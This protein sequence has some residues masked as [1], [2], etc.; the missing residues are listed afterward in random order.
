[1]NSTSLTE[2]RS[3]QSPSLQ[4]MKR[5]GREQAMPE[6]L[7]SEENRLAEPRLPEEKFECW[8]AGVEVFWPEAKEGQRRAFLRLR[9]EKTAPVPFQEAFGYEGVKARLE[10]LGCLLGWKFRI[11]KSG[12]FFQVTKEKE[13]P[14]EEQVGEKLSAA[15]AELPATLFTGADKEE[16]KGFCQQ[17]KTLSLHWLNEEEKNWAVAKLARL[18]GQLGLAVRIEIG[19]AGKISLVRDD[20]RK[21]EEALA[22]VRLLAPLPAKSLPELE[23]ACRQYLEAHAGLPFFEVVEG[24]S[25]GEKG[26]SFFENFRRAFLYPLLKERRGELEKTQRIAIFTLARILGGVEK[27]NLRALGDW[28]Q[29]RAAKETDLNGIF[30]AILHEYELRSEGQVR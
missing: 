1:M 19:D 25:Q 12:E 21:A 10:K 17:G 9:G 27:A 22:V 16:L 14:P 24:G 23:L 30:A 5:G 15:L 29:L 7:M 18:F 3:K 11:E 6:S 4:E 28:E 20:G 2:T 8:E 13:L 26:E